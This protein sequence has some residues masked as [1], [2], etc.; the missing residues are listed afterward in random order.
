MRKALLRIG[1]IELPRLLAR[2]GGG[3]RQVAAV[4]G[5]DLLPFA[6]QDVAQELPELRLERLYGRAIEKEV[7]A[8][9]QRIAAVLKALLA[10]HDES[11]AFARG[12]RDGFDAA[13]TLGLRHHRPGDPVAIRRQLDGEHLLEAKSLPVLAGDHLAASLDVFAEVRV[14]L[15]PVV[16]HRRLEES[17]GPRGRVSIGL[18][19]LVRP[20]A[21]EPPPPPRSGVLCPPARAPC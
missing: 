15:V 9:R 1:S 4:A 21:R 14:P 5:D 6:A 10:G 11:A 2:D 20:F 19:R 16:E 12:Q 8:A 17:R 18:D 7:D 13:D 3:E